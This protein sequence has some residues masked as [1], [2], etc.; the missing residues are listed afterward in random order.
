MFGWLF[1]QKK[2]VREIWGFFDDLDYNI[3]NTGWSDKNTK[4][5]EH[6]FDEVYKDIKICWNKNY[7]EDLERS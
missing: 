3:C 5:I 7:L 6:T 4:G 1:L 2:N